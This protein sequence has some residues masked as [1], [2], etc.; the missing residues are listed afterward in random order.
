LGCVQPPVERGRQGIGDLH[1]LPG[2]ARV[3]VGH[4]GPVAI[5]L[6][7]NEPAVRRGDCPQVGELLLFEC[8]PPL[9]GRADGRWPE[10]GQ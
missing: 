10:G 9:I 7:V 2:A 4:L 5:D 6:I 8:E 1:A 3:R